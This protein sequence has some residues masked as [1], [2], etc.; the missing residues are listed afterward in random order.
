MASKY[1]IWVETNRSQLETSIYKAFTGQTT[2]DEEKPE[3]ETF[4]P[5]ES[6]NEEP[7]KTV[8]MM[9]QLLKGV[10]LMEIKQLTAGTK[11][12]ES[13]IKVRRTP[14]IEG[15]LLN[16]NSD[17]T[18][19][20]FG[21]HVTDSMS[22]E[23]NVVVRLFNQTK[24]YVLYDS[25]TKEIKRVQIK[26]NQIATEYVPKTGE[27]SLNTYGIMGP[28]DEELATKFDIRTN[29]TIIPDPPLIDILETIKG[30]KELVYTK[31]YSITGRKHQTIRIQRNY[32]TE[33]DLL[34]DNGSQRIMEVS[35]QIIKYLSPSTARINYIRSID[36]VNEKGVSV[37]TYRSRNQ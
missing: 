15:D 27:P 9:E 30:I 31:F 3:W 17:E 24:G 22:D 12:I 5:N 1:E 19:K 11:N 26:Y 35:E 28:S 32:P 21:E 16:D 36:F 29:V 37:R 20:K 13:I 7:P 10:C 23:L 8:L 4:D 25:K 2:E 34:A 18:I 6:P 14:Q 33:G